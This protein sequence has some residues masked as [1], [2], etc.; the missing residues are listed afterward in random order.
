MKKEP[1]KL[2][3]KTKIILFLILFISNKAIS[4]SSFPI[5]ESFQIFHPEY[6]EQG[7][8]ASQEKTASEIGAKILKQGGNAV[9]AAVAVGYALAVTLPKAGNIGGGGFMLV[10]LNKEKKSIVINYREKAPFAATK[11]MFLDKKGRVN[12]DEITTSYNGAGVPGTVYGL[13]LALKKYGT[14]PLKKVMEP[15]INLARNG[16]TVTH[17]LSISLTESMKHLQKNEESTRIFFKKNKEPYNPGET[18]YQKDLAN[19]LEEI[20]NKGTDAFYRGSIAKKIVEDVKTHKGIMTLKDLQDYKAIEMSPI[21]GTYNGFTVL[22]VPPPSSGGVT[23][24]EILNILENYDFK[25]IPFRSAEYFHILSEAMNFAYYDRNNSLGDPDF[26][27]NP[28]EKLISK[29]YAKEIFQKIDLKNHIPSEIV[30]K[31]GIRRE[32]NQDGNTTHYSVVD[33]FGNMV[34]NTYTLN[35]Y[36]GNGKTAKGTGILLNNEMD[37]FTAKV[38]AANSFGLV[39]GAKNSIEP[40]KRPLSSMTPTILL[41]SKKEAILATGAPGGSR[42]ITQSLLMI[43]GFIDY[44][45]NI[46]SLASYPRFHRQL[47][48]DKFYYEDGIAYE[49]LEVLKKMGHDIERVNPYGSLQTVQKNIEN[50][51]L[52]SSDPRSEGDAAVGVW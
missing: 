31:E 3:I 34:S 19:T 43:T 32:S 12:V 4:A 37:D 9:D 17:A 46:A 5:E 41:N 48:P 47:W 1:R 51:F 27:K 2:V 40:Q 10:W 25:K 26:V 49:T 42:I 39:Q 15:A 35:Y 14:L 23:L 45:K 22:S 50:R 44:Q 8:V 29:K 28:I 24:I 36:Y 16:I 20:A 7:M 38:G 11:D 21:E 13:N 33:K 52:G 6:S 18:L 30:Q